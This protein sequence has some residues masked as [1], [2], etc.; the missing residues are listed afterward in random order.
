M[1]TVEASRRSGARVPFFAIAFSVLGAL[2]PNAHSQPAYPVKPIHLSVPFPSGGVSD[3]SARMVA[4]QLSKRLGQQVVVENRPGASGNVAGQYIA[5]A[6]PDGYTILLAYNGLVTINPFV[7]AKMAFDTVKD[8]APIGKIGDYPSLIA[9]HPAVEAKTIRDLVALSKTRAAGLDFGT[10][11]NGSNEHLIGTL[12]VQRAGAR[13]VHVP[14][15]G[16]G[17]ALVDAIAGHIP[18]SMSSV[19]GA[20][21]HVRAGK[22][23]AIAVTSAERWPTLPDVPTIVESGIADVVVVSWIGLVGP[24]RMP[25][26]IIDRL[27]EELN[28]A[29]AGA[30][31]RDKIAGLGVR[32]TPGTADAFRD[33][34]RR[35]LERNGP[36]I[37]A[38]R[39]SVE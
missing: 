37:R 39:I 17:P 4:E 27:N 34:I 23:R 32:A 8:L 31:L 28:A 10:S 20:T 11:G 9:V 13:L 38:A 15:K 18:I 2:Q 29:L 22:L 24:G 19:A 25:K 6:E 33:E 21:P 35:D 30:E 12:L 14:Y 36:I 7:F 3:A 16:G 1:N 5:Q 26:P